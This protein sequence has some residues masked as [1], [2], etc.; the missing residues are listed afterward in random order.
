[1]EI[2]VPTPVRTG[3]VRDGGQHGIGVALRCA[4]SLG[5][6]IAIAIGT[7]VQAAD[8]AGDPAPGATGS[9]PT[10]DPLGDVPAASSATSGRITWS[11]GRDLV[12]EV[13]LD[14]DL[15]I[16]DGKTLRTVAIAQ[17][18]AIHL[19]P[20]TEAMDRA[21]RFITPGQVAK[22][23]SG[24]PYP[25][26][27][28]SAVVDLVDGS[29]IA[30]HLY[31]TVVYI[32]PG[33][34]VPIREIT[35]PGSKNSTVVRE[36]D[37]N[38]PERVILLAK[39]QGAP[40]TTLAS[41]VFPNLIIPSPAADAPPPTAH[42]ITF[43]AKAI[44]QGDQVVVIARDGLAR[45]ETAAGAT[46]EQFTLPVAVTA[47]VFVAR[48]AAGGA[49][50]A[51]W[52]AGDDAELHALVATAVHDSLDF[53]DDRRLLAVT[54]DGD[55]IYG[56][57]MLYRAGPTTDG[58]QHPWRLEIWRWHRDDNRLLWAGR[59]WFF[60]DRVEDAKQLPAVTIDHT[61]WTQHEARGG[62]VIGAPASP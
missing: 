43:P 20:E 57:L 27:H 29:S 7:T 32:T 33:G 13:R 59:A 48:Q 34:E 40:G 36:I 8:P 24:D 50:T 22:E 30:G 3:A 62:I 10:T 45:T 31:T 51:A 17:V 6:L 38:R 12:G 23:Y 49:L 44:A 25:V 39:Q 26:R 28:L 18:R 60:R 4:F 9:A 41:L 1:M 46:A 55:Q 19:K 11:D 58:P 14:K 37:D 16:H 35:M 2:C 15:E 5:F 42:T 21:W 56:L 53:M 52:P 61:W 47:P 54:A